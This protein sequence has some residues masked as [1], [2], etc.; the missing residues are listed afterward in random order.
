MGDYFGSVGWGLWG[1]IV[2]GWGRVGYYFG[3]VVVS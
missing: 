1:I 2:G 3:W